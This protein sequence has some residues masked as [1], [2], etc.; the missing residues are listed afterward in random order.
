MARALLLILVLLAFPALARAADPAAEA[1]FQDAIALMKEGRFAEACP[2]L[3]A[4]QAREAKSGTLL[5]LGSCHEQLGQTATAW[6]E[7]TEAATLART[8]GRSENAE[9]A[10]EFAQAVAPLLSRLTIDVA[11]QPVEIEVTLDGVRIA[12][13][14]YGT[15]LPVDPGPHQVEAQA[16][17]HEP[18]SGSITVGA[19]ADQQTL[20]VPALV[21]L[22]APV[23]PLPAMPPPPPAPI[24]PAPLPDQPEADEGPPLWVWVVGGTGLALLAASVAFRVDQAA[25]GNALDE[26]CGA[27]RTA[28]PPSYD[29]MADRAR[30]ERSFGLF[31]G[32][33]AGGVVALGAAVIGL[34]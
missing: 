10:Q 17:G 9:K 16:A 5:V 3:A 13:A 4:S 30:E 15:A 28:C 24:A 8:E 29:F 6:A 1:L 26:Q 12:P 2:K 33:G 19:D 32:F 14:T 11:A 21:P 25:A 27:D 34:F 23:E 31:L 20:T 22:P 7:Y 18:W